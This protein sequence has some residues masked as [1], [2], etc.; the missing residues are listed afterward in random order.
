M[1]MYKLTD[2]QEAVINQ[3]G[4]ET[5]NQGSA[6]ELYDVMQHGATAGVGGFIY[7]TDTTKFFDANKDLIMQQLLEDRWGIGYD[8]LTQ[9]L[10]SF[11]CFK[12]IKTYNIEMFLINPDNEDNED[13]EDQQTL[14]NGLAWYAL[15]EV[16]SQLECEIDELLN[17]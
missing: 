7:Y 11:N 17:H 9:M 13:N 14:K 6:Q 15:E 10:S 5:L 12:G 3:L 2:L 4:Y 16:A 1:T 8:S